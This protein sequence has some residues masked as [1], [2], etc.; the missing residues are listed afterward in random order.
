M[1]RFF[2]VH[3]LFFEKKLF[4]YKTGFVVKPTVTCAPLILNMHVIHGCALDTE[5]KVSEFFINS[6]LYVRKKT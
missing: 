2:Y 6:C 5:L 3:G 4:N 1:L